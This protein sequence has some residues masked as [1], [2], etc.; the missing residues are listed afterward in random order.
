MPYV[1]QKKWLG[2]LSVFVVLS[3]TAIL[4]A[5]P[6][7]RLIER[8]IEEI[9]NNNIKNEIIILADLLD[10]LEIYARNWEDGREVMIIGIVELLKLLKLAS[11]L[12]WQADKQKVGLEIQKINL[13]WKK[14]LKRPSF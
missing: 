7:K 5:L 9:K 2:E 10:M 1:T 14:I 8:D 3:I 6:K 13:G 12:A 4:R 11:L